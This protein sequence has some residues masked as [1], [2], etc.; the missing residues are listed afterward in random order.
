MLTPSGEKKEIKKKP[1]W[2]NIMAALLVGDKKAVK[3]RK[4]LKHKTCCK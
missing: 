3:I 1:Q 2:P 4:T